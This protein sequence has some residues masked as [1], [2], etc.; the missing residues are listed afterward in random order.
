MNDNITEEQLQ[1]IWKNQYKNSSKLITTNNIEVVVLFQGE[2]NIHSGPDFINAHIKI[3]NIDFWGSVEVHCKSSDWYKH[4]HDKDPAYNNVIL[5]V[6]FENDQTVLFIEKYL[7]TVELKN[8][9]D[10][11]ILHNVQY[12]MNKSE[13][14]PCKK[15][16]RLMIDYDKLILHRF[17]RKTSLILSIL[18][19]NRGNW[20]NTSFQMLLYTFGFGV[21][22]KGMLQLA[23]SI[24]YKIIQKNSQNINVLYAILFGQANLIDKSE[25]S[26]INEIKKEYKFIRIKYQISPPNI[27]WHFS[28]LRP[29]NF[30]TVRIKQI[31]QILHHKSCFLKWV[32]SP[33]SLNNYKAIFNTSPKL[34]RPMTDT[35]LINFIIPLQLTYN[36]T[37]GINSSD[38]IFNILKNVNSENNYIVRKWNEINPHN[39][40]ESQ[41]LI[42]LYN[43]YCKSYKCLQCFVKLYKK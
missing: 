31:C 34:S 9:V 23:R 32:I 15:I 18:S 26:N 29:Y 36:K 3:D 8:F 24:D 27:N 25:L 21:N 37:H 39:S 38:K 30:P 40:Y 2:Y 33:F 20:E 14:I 7:P 1:F 19:D 41:A 10:D 22:C 4:N 6:V 16:F 35:L 43:N 5:H 12:L 28:K 13:D 17:N 11:T 42:E